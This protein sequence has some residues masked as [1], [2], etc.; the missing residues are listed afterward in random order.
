MLR[1][2]SLLL[3][4]VVASSAVAAEEVV[5][6]KVWMR[7]SVPG[8]TAVTVQ[9]N[10]TVVRAAT[11]TGVS[12]PLARQGQLL[13]VLRRPGQMVRKP[14]PSLRLPPHSTTRF[15]EDG[16]YLLLSGLK[17]PLEV[18]QRVPVTLRLQIGGKRKVIETQA[19]VRALELSYRHY[20]DPAVMDHQ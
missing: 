20:N 19:A 2:L 11:L 4:C 9:L 18:G 6:D 8:Q 14:L 5:V 10:L 17:Q 12:S 7:E 13:R 1:I 3:G 16:L 15:G